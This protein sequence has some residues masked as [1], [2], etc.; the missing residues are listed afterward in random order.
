[1]P[2]IYVSDPSSIASRYL[3]DPV[4]EE[5]LREWIDQ[6]GPDDT[7]HDFA[8]AA[9]T[10]ERRPFVTYWFPLTADL[11]IRGENRLGLA[12]TASAAGA[13][14]SIVVE[15][16]EILVVPSNG[17]YDR[18]STIEPSIPRPPSAQV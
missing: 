15:E 17:G 4:T 2:V 6:V 10:C 3:P 11:C 14:D 12:L 18:S 5:S 9:L 1:M 13:A 16:V 7:P 8:R